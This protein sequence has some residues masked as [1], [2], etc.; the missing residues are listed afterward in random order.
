MAIAELSNSQLIAALDEGE[1]F[2]LSRRLGDSAAPDEIKAEAESLH[3]TGRSA[4]ARAK[5]S[6]GL[7]GREYRGETG[8]W[9]TTGKNVVVFFLITR[10]N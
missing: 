6:K 8:E 7:S 10:M 3:N 9:V 2:T 4:I 5:K 1:S